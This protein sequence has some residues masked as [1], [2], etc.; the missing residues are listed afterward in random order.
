MD[1]FIGRDAWRNWEE[2]HWYPFILDGQC[3]RIA[4]PREAPV[5]RSAAELERERPLY[6][7]LADAVETRRD[8]QV[9]LKGNWH[10]LAVDFANTYF[11]PVTST[12]ASTRDR[13]PVARFGDEAL[14]VSWALRLKRALAEGAGAQ[15]ERGGKCLYEAL[16]AVVQ[17]QAAVVPEIGASLPLRPP[18]PHAR[19]EGRPT[20]RFR[21]YL[22]PSELRVNHDRYLEVDP[23]RWIAVFLPKLGRADAEELAQHVAPQQK[24]SGRS[25]EIKPLARTEAERRVRELHNAYAGDRRALWWLATHVLASLLNLKLTGAVLTCHATSRFQDRL[26]RK[27]PQVS[28]GFRF[29]NSLARIWFGLW[30][31]WSGTAHKLCER[32]GKPFSVTQKTRRFCSA[33]CQNATSAQRHRDRQTE[34]PWSTKPKSRRRRKR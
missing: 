33:K 28:V 12:Y 34:V 7:R 11:P 25:D 17:I 5:A 22:F 1:S 27:V 19:E 26:Q 31:D 30:E 29:M 6:L 21:K 15:G 10:Q 4:D 20:V 14:L 23:R 24:V 3:L 16:M 32:C 13:I 2:I 9:A 18:A 8:G